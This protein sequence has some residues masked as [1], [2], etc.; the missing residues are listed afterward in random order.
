MNILAMDTVG[1]QGSVALLNGDNLTASSQL[2]TPT[3]HVVSLPQAISK[4]LKEADLVMA[5][6]DLVAVT[7]GP[8]S[9][10]GLRIALGMAKGLAIGQGIDVVGIST[11]E[12][13]ATGGGGTKD[14]DYVAS[15]LDARRKEVFFG[16]YQLVDGGYPKSI[17]QPVITDPATLANELGSDPIFNNQP[18]FMNGTGIESYSNLFVDALGDRYVPA[19]ASSWQPDPFVLGSL[20]RQKFL[21]HGGDNPANLQPIYLRRPDAVVKKMVL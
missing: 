21:K 18:I 3:G 2:T 10:T 14:G 8:G 6:M 12:V 1:Q 4:L 19:S 7:L 17:R 5:D 13:V 15:L 20:G 16:L 9:F 11:L